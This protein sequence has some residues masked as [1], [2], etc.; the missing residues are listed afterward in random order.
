MNVASAGASAPIRTVAMP[1][2]PEA[3]EGPE[4]ATMNDHD[5][6]D[7]SAAAAKPAPA[8]APAAPGTGTTID[9]LA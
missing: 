9:K 6:D 7:V 5:S 3:V 8:R 2:S 4:T 1:A